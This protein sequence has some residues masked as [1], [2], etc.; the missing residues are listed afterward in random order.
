MQKRKIIA[1]QMTIR[2]LANRNNGNG[3]VYESKY[4]SISIS[5]GFSIYSVIDKA[6][7]PSIIKNIKTLNILI[8]ILCY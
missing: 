6:N 2:K 8:F 5:T 1:P 7:R 3:A 4:R